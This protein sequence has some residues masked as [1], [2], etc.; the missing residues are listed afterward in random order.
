MRWVMISG[1]L[2]WTLFLFNHAAK[3]SVAEVDVTTKSV[4]SK[5]RGITVTYD[6]KLGQK[7]V[8]LDVSRKATITVNG[9]EGTLESVKPGQKAKVTFEKELQ[10]VARWGRLRHSLFRGFPGC[11]SIVACR[12]PFPPPAH[13]TGRAVLPHPA[14]GQESMRS[15]TERCAFSHAAGSSS[16]H[17]CA[18]QQNLYL[19]PLPHGQGA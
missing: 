8:D 10:V 14:I 15:P 7:S 1:V 2:V 19:R 18:P 11:V 4:D 6:T 5:A 16:N 3:A 12:A 9:K 17:L 13:Q